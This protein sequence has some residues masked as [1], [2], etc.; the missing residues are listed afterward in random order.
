[1]TNLAQ[2]VIIAANNYG[3][4]NVWEHVINTAQLHQQLKGY[5]PNTSDVAVYEDDSIALYD[6]SIKKWVEDTEFK[7]SIGD[8]DVTFNLGVINF[9]GYDACLQE[10]QSP[11]GSDDWW[12]FGEDGAILASGSW[13]TVTNWIINNWEPL[14]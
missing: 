14:D 2:Q 8:H 12:R 7:F 1:M 6:Y 9:D 11:D 4:G 3:G 5:T 10:K 13:D